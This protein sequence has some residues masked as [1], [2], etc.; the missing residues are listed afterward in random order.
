MLLKDP[1]ER[2]LS[3]YLHH[4]AHQSLDV[5]VPLLAAPGRL[6][7]LALSRYGHHLRHWLKVF[8]AEQLLVLPDPQGENT[9]QILQHCCRFLDIDD[10][11]HFAQSGQ[12]VFPGLLRLRRDDGLWVA[13]GQR[14]VEDVTR[15]QR[16]LPLMNFEGRD[17]VRLVHAA[18]IARIKH[19]LSDDMANFIQQLKQ[20]NINSEAFA[21][22]QVLGNSD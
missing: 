6:G 19:M 15:I 2:T 5:N 12:T 10:Q 17:Y 11:H 4:I 7:L 22:W 13:L 20:H 9:Q 21:H 18:E 8:P 1:V 14:G 3:G 16:P